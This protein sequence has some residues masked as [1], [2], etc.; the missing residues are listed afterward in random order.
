MMLGQLRNIKKPKPV[1]NFLRYGIDSVFTL[2]GVQVVEGI[3]S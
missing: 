3:I 2:E 1:A